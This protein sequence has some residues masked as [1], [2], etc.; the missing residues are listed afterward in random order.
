M[1]SFGKSIRENKNRFVP[2][3]KTVRANSR[4]G[5]GSNGALLVFRNQFSER[6]RFGKSIQESKNRFVPSCKIMGGFDLR[7]LRVLRE[8][9]VLHRPSSL[10]WHSRA[11]SMSH[12]SSMKAFCRFFVLVIGLATLFSP[13]FAAPA[14]DPDAALRELVNRQNA[15]FAEAEKNDPKFDQDNFRSQLQQLSDEYNQLIRAY[16]EFATAYAAYGLMLSKSDNRKE[17][18]A[19]FLQANRLNKNMPM[20]KNEIGNYLAEEGHPVDALNYYLGAIQLAPK[21]PLYHYQLGTLLNEGR[22]DFLQSGQWTRDV[23]DQTM[24]QAFQKAAELA[25]DNIGYAYRYG[26]SFY[27]L[28]KPDWDAALAYWKK[29]ENRVAPGIEQQT[30]RLH[31]ANVLIKQQKFAEA[32][33]LI[34]GINEKVLDAQ[35]QKL[36]AMLPPEKKS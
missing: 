25:P 18:L 36:V 13:A 3:C 1:L 29:L 2:S 10:R 8:T 22:D 6:Y 11:V 19:M 20:V 15:L 34:D 33:T 30:I 16:P 17:A 21:E 24:Q 9:P 4:F 28:A 23:I 27:D 26:E 35:K 31:E 5:T 12:E 32:K 7:G 14:R